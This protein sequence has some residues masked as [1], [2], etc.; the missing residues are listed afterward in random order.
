MLKPP[1]QRESSTSSASG[2]LAAL[3]Q[4]RAAADGLRPDPA[5]DRAAAALQGLHEGLGRYEAAEHAPAPGLLR[6]LARR[7]VPAPAPRGIYLHGAV[8]R[9]KTMLMDLFFAGAPVARKRRVH[10]SAFMLETHDR[11]HRLRRSMP[12]GE[13]VPTLAAALAAEARLL[14]L[15]ELQIDNIAD[16]M[17][18]AR[19]FEAILQAGAVVVA[20]SNWAPDALYAGGLQRERVLP[21]IALIKQ[22]FDIVFLD[23]GIDYRRARLAGMQVYHWPLGAAAEQALERDFGVLTEG[24]AAA[25]IDIEVQGRALHVPR[26]ARDVAWLTFEALC[27]APRGTADYLALA[28]RFAVVAVSSI[29]L[30]TNERREEARRFTLL[31]DVLYERATK[32]LCSAAA[33]PDRLFDIPRDAVVTA[34]AVSRLLEMQSAAYLTRTREE[35]DME[36]R[37]SLA[38]A[39]ERE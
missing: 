26:A 33:P 17:L 23:G 16:A 27:G 19:L 6:L 7:R 22:R 39:V 29:P 2:P 34:R 36:S 24:L 10:F 14:C 21:F 1:E 8:G 11:L 28:Q 4:R 20:T 31:L 3:G 13:A 35:N 38:L 12:A 25:P 5:Q 37:R 32:L 9:G 30:L 15:D 18:V